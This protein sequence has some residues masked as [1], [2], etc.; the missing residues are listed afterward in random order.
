MWYLRTQPTTYRPQTGITLIETIIV[1]GVL[2]IIVIV[3]LAI[4]PIVKASVQ[5]NRETNNI[6]TIAASLDSVYAGVGTYAGLNNL[7]AVQEK[8][9]PANMV[10][11]PLTAPVVTNSLGGSVTVAPAMPPGGQPNSGFTITSTN[12]T[13]DTCTKIVSAENGGFVE[14]VVDG[15]VV[16]AT[17]S[18]TVSISTLAALCVAAATSDNHTLTFYGP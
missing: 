2:A 10:S 16:K 12:I 5:S 6:T 8:V 11:G 3:A 15:T 13:D 14:V 17:S 4:Y 9:F 7:V 1:L 18:D